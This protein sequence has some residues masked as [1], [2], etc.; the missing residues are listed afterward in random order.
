MS[1][2]WGNPLNASHVQRTLNRV[3]EQAGLAH[4]TYELRHTTASLLIDAGESVEH[5][6]DLL[7]D[8]PGAAPRVSRSAPVGTHS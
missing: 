7:G 3:R 1:P 5:V 2:S 8:N 6:A 4:T